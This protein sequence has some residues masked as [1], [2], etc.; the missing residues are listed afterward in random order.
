[1]DKSAY[2]YGQKVKI[3]EGLFKGNIG[4]FCQMKDHERVLVLISFLGRKLKI[5]I[6][7]LHIAAI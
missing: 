5:N 7:S 1:M 3:N 4:Q 2:N 6:S